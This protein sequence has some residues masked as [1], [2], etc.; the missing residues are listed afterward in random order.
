[1]VFLLELGSVSK[2]MEDSLIDTIAH[3]R[4]IVVSQSSG[5]CNFVSGSGRGG[6]ILELIK[7]DFFDID[8]VPF[9]Q[10]EFELFKKTVVSTRQKLLSQEETVRLTNYNPLLLSLITSLPF[11]KP[12]GAINKI[13]TVIRGAVADISCSLKANKF[14][15]ISESLPKSMDM[16][17]KAANGV[18]LT[19]NEYGEYLQ[20]WIHAEHITFISK[21]YKRGYLLEMNFPT[22]YR[23]LLKMLHRHKNEENVRKHSHIIDGAYFEDDFCS[24]VKTLNVIYSKKE[25]GMS[26]RLDLK[27]I[28]FSFTASVSLTFGSPLKAV[29]EGI[30]YQLRPCHPVIDAVAYVKV[31]KIQW[32][33]LIQVSLS[34]YDKHRSQIQHLKN[35][36]IGCEKNQPKED[37]PKPTKAGKSRENGKTRKNNKSEKTKENKPKR[38]RLKKNDDATEINWINYYSKMVPQEKDMTLQ[39]MYIYISPRTFGEK[40]PASPVT[41]YNLRSSTNPDERQIVFFGLALQG[42]PSADFINRLEVLATKV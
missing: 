9:T 6:R 16:L 35:Y 11:Q 1:M 8:F 5:A 10:Q 29:A 26:A 40:V 42:S 38:K 7:R 19:E 39:I 27:A 36:V 28:T 17:I 31:K 25:E 18:K 4:L 21:H 41:N 30:L 2:D 32:L 14:D 3:F 22:C 12:N 24:Q 15:R 34:A 23:E 37:K 20:T 13:K 33:L